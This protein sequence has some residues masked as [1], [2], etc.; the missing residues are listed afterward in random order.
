MD[1][2]WRKQNIWERMWKFT[3]GLVL[4]E[5]TITFVNSD[6]DIRIM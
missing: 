4:R 3:Y 6:N 2:G 1:P 5:V